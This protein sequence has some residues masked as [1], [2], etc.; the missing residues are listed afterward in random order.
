[1]LDH[2]TTTE[3]D[4]LL[5]SLRGEREHHEWAIRVLDDRIRSTAQVLAERL[6][7]PGAPN[8]VVGDR[9]HTA[10]WTGSPVVACVDT[11]MVDGRNV[12]LETGD[13]LHMGWWPHRQLTKIGEA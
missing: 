2:L 13:G 4:Q 5:V 1:M 7:E 12:R 3:I 9:V 11:S 8:F 6:A 10:S